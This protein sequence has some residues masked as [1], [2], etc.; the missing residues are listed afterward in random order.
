MENEEDTNIQLPNDRD[1]MI[2]YNI[3]L[4]YLDSF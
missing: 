1:E 2:V 4:T 3:Q